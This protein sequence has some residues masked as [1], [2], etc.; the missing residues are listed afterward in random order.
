MLN[1]S[2]R[3]CLR[4]LSRY[5]MTREGT[6]TRRTA[7]P[8]TWTTASGAWVHAYLHRKEG[9]VGNASY[10]YRQAGRPIAK[11]SFDDEWRAIVTALLAALTCTIVL[12]Q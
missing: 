5:G 4:R 1:P 3:R 12:V 11:G 8:R 7:W 10:W 6:G 9:D 2:R